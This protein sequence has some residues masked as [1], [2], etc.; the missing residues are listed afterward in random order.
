MLKHNLLDK[1]KTMGNTKNIKMIL[2]NLIIKSIIIIGITY[3]IVYKI[4]IGNSLFK[5][6]I[7]ILSSL[8]IFWFFSLYTGF[9][10]KNKPLFE[11]ILVTFFIFIFFG[12][13][14]YFSWVSLTHIIGLSYENPLFV[15]YFVMLSVI[16]FIIL[17]SRYSYFNIIKI[18]G[19]AIGLSTIG[20][21]IFTFSI[22]GTLNNCNNDNSTDL[23]ES[24]YITYSIY[25]TW[26][27]LIGLFFYADII[28]WGKPKFIIISL[29]IIIGLIL[30][31]YTW[32]ECQSFGNNGEKIINNVSWINTSINIT[33]TVSYF[34][35][36]IG[37]YLSSLYFGTM[38]YFILDVCAPKND[39]RITAVSTLLVLIL[40]F[41]Y[42]ISKL[43]SHFST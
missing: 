9:F 24:N 8:I 39:T 7:I 15:F 23:P 11:D 16:T 4:Y 34:N 38:G 12:T 21:F 31:Y 26:I 20:I 32:K 28:K 6:F 37:H 33:T 42:L 13:L 19:L 30:I 18:I 10:W 17:S 3:V 40:P 43:K 41:V 36:F 14:Y 29:C 2:L 35:L 5:N 1:T 27:V 25:F 22:L